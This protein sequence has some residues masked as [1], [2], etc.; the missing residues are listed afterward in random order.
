MHASLK[1]K[2]GC[3][4]VHKS[5]L[6]SSTSSDY[7]YHACFPAQKNTSTEIML[8]LLHNECDTNQPC[9]FVKQEHYNQARLSAR[10]HVYMF[11]SCLHCFTTCSQFRLAFC[12]THTHACNQSC[13]FDP[14]NTHIHTKSLLPHIKHSETQTHTKNLKNQSGLNT[15]FVH[16]VY[17][18]PR[19]Y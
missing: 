13:F 11:T 12:G 4:D 17:H 16:N 6:L 1:C 15:V 8:D 14:Q 2:H 5:S 19:H 3:D 10:V 9:S 18:K 7:M